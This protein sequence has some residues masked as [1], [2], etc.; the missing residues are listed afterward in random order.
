VNACKGGH[1][2]FYPRHYLKDLHDETD[3]WKYTP[4]YVVKINF[5]PDQSKI[6]RTLH[7]GEIKVYHISFK[8]EIIIQNLL[9]YMSLIYEGVSK[10]FRTESLTK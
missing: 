9:K 4:Q 7:E 8:K 1:I 6:A 10:S 5:G 2:R 3:I